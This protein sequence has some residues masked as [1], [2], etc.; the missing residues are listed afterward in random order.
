LLRGPGHQPH[1]FL[2]TTNAHTPDRH[3][4]PFTAPDHSRH[5]FTKPQQPN[6]SQTSNE[7]SQ[8]AIISDRPHA[9]A[10]A[11]SQYLLRKH[12]LDYS[13]TQMGE[14][15]SAGRSLNSVDSGS[16]IVNVGSLTPPP[17]M[18][19][20]SSCPSI[21]EVCNHSSTDALFTQQPLLSSHPTSGNHSLHSHVS[22]HNNL[23][24]RRHSVQEYPVGAPAVSTHS[25]QS[26]TGLSDSFGKLRYS[27]YPASPTQ[28]SRHSSSGSVSSRPS[29]SFEVSSSQ[30]SPAMGILV[31]PATEDS[32][33]RRSLDSYEPGGV[34]VDLGT[35]IGDGRLVKYARLSE[36]N[37]RFCASTA[38][39]SSTT[40]SPAAAGTLRDIVGVGDTQS[41]PIV[42]S[43]T[44]CF[45]AWKQKQGSVLDTPANER[46]ARG[47]SIGRSAAS[48]RLS[49]EYLMNSCLNPG[50]PGISTNSNSSLLINPT[51]PILAP[52]VS[53]TPTVALNQVSAVSLLPPLP[54]ISSL[55][56]ISALSSSKPFVCSFPPCTA[57]F[58]RNHDLKR[59]ELIHT[60]ERRYK[61]KECGRAFGRR[62]ALARHLT[63]TPPATLDA[64]S[65]VTGGCKALYGR[66]AMW[67]RNK[68]KLQQEK[69]L[70]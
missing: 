27:V 67:L 16:S 22:H 29:L 68:L 5:S 20:N 69:Q 60:G 40:N 49:Q 15:F 51:T 57:R 8:Q 11:P 66:K 9:I 28:Y 33:R 10:R 59:H 1:P 63:A 23:T 53:S 34:N 44:Y 52:Y 3:T 13:L 46:S 18:V 17:F 14:S 12:S 61:C 36:S 6:Y 4:Q 48:N 42:P 31:N 25:R 54:E 37:S 43:H 30:C 19:R 24:F 50:T 65:G 55:S 58:S 26:T 32:K 35:A 45:V 56:C 64:G 70:K 39:S 7:E 41:P 47:K 62:D 2:V 21:N 38:L